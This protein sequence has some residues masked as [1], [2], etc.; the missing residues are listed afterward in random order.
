MISSI[1]SKPIR[2][3]KNVF[4]L[5][6]R[7]RR[8]R[9]RR[10]SIRWYRKNLRIFSHHTETQI[11][12]TDTDSTKYPSIYIFSHRQT[13]IVLTDTDGTENI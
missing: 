11:V 9:R 13:Q 10:R 3:K 4:F 2:R 12:L 5:E 8:R 6:E 7:R 1:S